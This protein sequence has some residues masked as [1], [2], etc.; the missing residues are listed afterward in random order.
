MTAII[1]LWRRAARGTAHP[2]RNIRRVC[3]VRSGLAR[4]TY[5]NES[6]GRMVGIEAKEVLGRAAWDS[7]PA[8]AGTQLQLEFERALRDNLA[9][10]V[11]HFEPRRRLCYENRAYPT[12]N[13]LRPDVGLL[14]L[15][16]PRIICHALDDGCSLHCG[17]PSKKVR[18]AR[19]PA[20]DG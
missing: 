13:G 7:L 2:F 10:H 19:C 16:M 6:A 4:Y 18:H 8:I 1:D 12:E 17:R 3:I 14:D 5:V 9:L 20:P 15:G 11:E